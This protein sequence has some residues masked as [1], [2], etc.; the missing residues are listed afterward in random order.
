M[1]VSDYYTNIETVNIAVNLAIDDL[2]LF[3]YDNGVN[4]TI[5]KQLNPWLRD[6][7]LPNYSANKYAIKLPNT[8]ETSGMKVDKNPNLKSDSLF[9]GQSRNCLRARFAF[10]Y[11]SP[12]T[13]P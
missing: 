9:N 12:S 8:T 10:N 2:A 7:S 13:Q 3:A 4:Y 5:L 6:T 11:P 1:R